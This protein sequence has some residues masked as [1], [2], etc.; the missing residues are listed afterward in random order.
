[1]G[2][3]EDEE[4]YATRFALFDGGNRSESVSVVRTGKLLQVAS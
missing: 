4:G 1:M 3:D 2:V